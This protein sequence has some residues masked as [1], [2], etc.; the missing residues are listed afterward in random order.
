MSF[1]ATS[2][3]QECVV[4]TIVLLELTPLGV[5]FSEEEIKFFNNL[6]LWRRPEKFFKNDDEAKIVSGTTAIHQPGNQ[7]TLRFTFDNGY[8]W[9]ASITKLNKNRI[10][11]CRKLA[12][13]LIDEEIRELANVA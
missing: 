3:L 12:Q 4:K 9:M 6:Y 10:K 1:Q 8:I 13:E 5:P 2:Y 11:E 7:K